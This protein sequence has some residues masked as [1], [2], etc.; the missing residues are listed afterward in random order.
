MIAVLLLIFA[1]LVLVFWG[2]SGD[3]GSHFT[4]LADYGP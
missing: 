1:A 2:A 4:Q 3:A